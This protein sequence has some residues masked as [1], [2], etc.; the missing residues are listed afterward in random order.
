VTAIPS[1]VLLWLQ[2]GLVGSEK[3]LLADDLQCFCQMNH[4]IITC[5]S[6]LICK[7]APYPCRCLRPR[8]SLAIVKRM[9]IVQNTE[10][11]VAYRYC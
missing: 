11:V 8:I 5:W 4:C 1:V 9:N 2:D 6:A 7:E 10:R 3:R